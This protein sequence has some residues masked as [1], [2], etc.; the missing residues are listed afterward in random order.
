MAQLNPTP[1]ER[2]K[3]A[4]APPQDRTCELADITESKDGG[5]LAAGDHRVEVA[6]TAYVVSYYLRPR[7]HLCQKQD[8]VAITT[9]PKVA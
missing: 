4:G 2:A 7:L 6:P 8:L 5:D 3:I 1:Q 9:H